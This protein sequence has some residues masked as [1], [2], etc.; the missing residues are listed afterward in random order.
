[1]VTNKE[2][3]LRQLNKFI[4]TTTRFTVEQAAQQE[5]DLFAERLRTL[6]KNA[7]LTQK[8]LSE[9][10]EIDRTLIVRYETA[11]S[12][13]RPKAIEKLAAALNVPPAALDINAGS[14]TVVDTALLRKHGYKARK[15]QNGLYAVSMP[16]CPEVTI[17][18]REAEDIW[19]YCWKETQEAFAD[20]MEDHF[21][22]LFIR[23][24]YAARSPEANPPK[25]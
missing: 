8:Q 13:P 1:M 4:E 25:E 21:T 6:R 10:T 23:E 3:Q 15:V 9:K 16:G 19:E 12:M 24:V 17:T 2:L 18:D 20:V 7:G 5:R 22:D 14:Y 11:K